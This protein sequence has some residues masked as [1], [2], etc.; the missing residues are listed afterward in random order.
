MPDRSF[1]KSRNSS[2]AEGI[3]SIQWPRN[4][5]FCGNRGVTLDD[6]FRVLMLDTG[7]GWLVRHSLK[8]LASDQVSSSHDDAAAA[9]TTLENSTGDGPAFNGRKAA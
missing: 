8:K 3:G 5:I 4:F 6:D 7:N 9:T 1:D 2:R